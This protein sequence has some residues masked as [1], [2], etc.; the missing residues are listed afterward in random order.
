M[1]AKRYSQS[2]P[3]VLTNMYTACKGN[4]KW[5]QI[6]KSI[7][8]LSL[9]TEKFVWVESDRNLTL[10]LITCTLLTKII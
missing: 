4:K 10:N 7:D 2:I 6:L 3:A 8:I 1:E 9:Q 5:V